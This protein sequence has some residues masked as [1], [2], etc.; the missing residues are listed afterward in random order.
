MNTKIKNL[1]A[2]LLI[3]QIILVKWLGQYPEF[4]ETYYSRD[5]YPYISGFWRS[6][7]G[8]IPISVGDILYALLIILGVRYIIVNRMEIKRNLLGF[9]R[10]IAM[11]LSVT[12]FTFHLLWGLNY[13]REPLSQTLALGEKHSQ[14]DLV[15]FVDQL[16]LK[17]NEIQFRITSD[18]STMV[19][20]PYSK[21]EIMDRTI[22]GYRSLANKIPLFTYHRPSLKKSIFSKPLSYMGYGGYLNPFTNEAQANSA[23]P[24]FRFPVICGHEIGHQLGFSAENETNFIGYLA[25]VSNEDIYFKYAAYAYALSYCLNELAGWDKEE[26]NRQYNKLNPGLKKNYR[27][28]ATFWEAHEN[29]M[30][31]V[32]KSIFNTFLKA[33]NQKDGIR[34]YNA[35]VTL[36]VNYYRINPL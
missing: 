12:Y 9:I 23:L 13:Y 22:E 10:D 27:E 18:T 2:I 19:Q 4:I 7:M 6:L 28:L 30:E 3:P 29:P 15:H 17:T 36:L 31:P 32:F 35:V 25:T 33:N 24:K 8:W 14:Q 34:S 11:I 26:F 1:I 5:I 21:K 16:V 20:V